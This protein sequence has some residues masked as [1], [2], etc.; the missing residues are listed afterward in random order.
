MVTPLGKDL[1]SSDAMTGKTINPTKVDS[2]PIDIKYENIPEESRK[3]FEAALQKEQ[4]EAKKRLL[5]C[6]GKTR[7]GMFEKEKF[8]MPTFAPPL[9]NPST[10]AT[11][12]ASFVSTPSDASFTYDSIMQFADVFLDRFEQSQKLTQDLLLDLS[13][14]N[15]GKKI[16]ND[17]SN[18]TPN[19]SL[20]AAPMENYQYGM[21]PNF[22]AGQTPLA[23]LS[24]AVQGQIGQIGRPD[25]LD[26]CPDGRA[27]QTDHSDR[28]DQ[29]HGARFCIT[30][31]T[32]DSSYFGWP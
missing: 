9:L 27:G 16:I 6:F 1:N 14:Q 8:A 28:S 4:E 20:S 10:T 19:P 18:F 7:Q 22:F 31:T 3:Q 13:L 23:R 29:C 25:Q 21:P 2:T 32:H 17:Y 15:K 26:R 30:A 12:S 11:S 5:A 24:S